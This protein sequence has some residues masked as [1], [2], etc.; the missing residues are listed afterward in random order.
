MKG[1]EITPGTCGGKPRVAG[2]RIRVMDIIVCYEQHGM[3]PADIVCFYPSLT[4]AEVHAALDYYFDH[5]H[6]VQQAIREEAQYVERVR[7]DVANRLNGRLAAGGE[8]DET[9][10]R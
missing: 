1:I 7:M 4:L 5:R 8:G 3:T 2:H 10:K 6:D 9:G